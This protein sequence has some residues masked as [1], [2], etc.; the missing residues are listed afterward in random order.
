VFG[1]ADFSQQPAEMS[2]TLS[3]FSIL[4]YIQK[5]NLPASAGSRSVTGVVCVRI[6]LG[7][8]LHNKKRRAL[9]HLSKLYCA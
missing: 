8:K 3:Y 6:L 1:L 5:G 7:T 9:A 4:N 2:L